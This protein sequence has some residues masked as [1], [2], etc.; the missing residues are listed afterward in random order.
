MDSS[1][2]VQSMTV[3]GSPRGTL[4]PRPPSS[5]GR[6]VSV[7]RVT[8]FSPK[9]FVP[10]RQAASGRYVLQHMCWSGDVSLQARL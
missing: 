7:A 6:R 3:E 8:A 10:V 2:E 9:T 4:S 1:Q 5:T